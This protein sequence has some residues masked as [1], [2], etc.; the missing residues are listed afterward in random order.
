MNWN[1]WRIGCA[2]DRAAQIALSGA[3]TAM[4]Q[5]VPEPAPIGGS[6]S[7]TVKATSNGTWRFAA[8]V[9]AP[10]LLIGHLPP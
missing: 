4:A 5:A 9:L 2:S 6:R 10:G 3:A 7:R 1:K 8:P